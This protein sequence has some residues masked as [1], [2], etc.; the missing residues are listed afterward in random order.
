VARPDESVPHRPVGHCGCGADLAGA[1]EVGI[2][3]S[4]QVHDLPE[5]RLRVRQHDVYRV[6]CGCGREHSGSLPAGVSSAPSS[7]GELSRSA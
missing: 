4:H 1:T 7:Y 5:I 2:E 3:H 6:C